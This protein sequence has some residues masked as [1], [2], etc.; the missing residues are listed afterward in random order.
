MLGTISIFDNLFQNVTM[1]YVSSFLVEA[2]AF[3]KEQMKRCFVPVFWP[4]VFLTFPEDVAVYS[5]ADPKRSRTVVAKTAWALTV[6]A[7]SAALYV[8]RHRLS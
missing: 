1:N 3:F 7:A 5:G 8:L 4:S 2:E 6:S